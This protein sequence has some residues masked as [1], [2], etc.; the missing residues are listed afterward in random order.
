MIQIILTIVAVTIISFNIDFAIKLWQITTRNMKEEDDGGPI[1]YPEYI[2][3][4]PFEA[5]ERNKE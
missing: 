3:V 2:V 4:N 1:F 5:L